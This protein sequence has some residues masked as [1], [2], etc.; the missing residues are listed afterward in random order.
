MVYS[1]GIWGQVQVESW[2]FL[3]VKFKNL[4]A[5]NLDWRFVSY[6]ILYMFK[7][8]SPKSSPSPSPTESKRLFYTSVSLLLSCIQGYRYLFIFQF[9]NNCFTIL[10]WFLQYISMNQPQIHICLL[11]Q[12]PPLQVAT[13]HQA[14]LPVLYSR[15]PV[16]KYS[17]LFLSWVSEFPNKLEF[18]LSGG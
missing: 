9:E 1:I 17:L 6:M 12:L 16:G 14:E 15:Q 8:H 11:P 5:S 2:W 4:L 13:E 18:R 3:K 7:C 10:C